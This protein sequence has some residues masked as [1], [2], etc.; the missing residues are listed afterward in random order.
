MKK[1]ALR[2]WYVLEDHPWMTMILG[3][4]AQTWFTL[5][6]R[7]LWFSDEVR[8]ADAY[9]N[10]AE[11]GHW[12]VLALNGQAYP[13]KPPVYFWF[14]WLLDTLTPADQPTVFFLGAALSGLFLLASAY[15][16]ARTLGFDRQVSLSAV[17]I[18]LSTFFLAGLFHYSRMDLMFAALIVL[19]HACLFRAFSEENQGRWP[20]WGF[21]LAGLATLVKGPLGFLFPLLTSTVYLIWKGEVKKFLTRPMGKGLL[22]MLLMLAAWVGGVILSQGP[23]FLLNTVLGHQILERATHTFH[24]M[25]PFYYYL[26]ALPL[27]WLPWTLFLFAAPVK[28]AFSLENW[29]ALWASR[30]EA[31]PRTFLWIMF[32]ATLIFLSSLSGKVLIYIL[33]MFPPMAILTG[34]AM[35]RQNEDDSVRFWTLA[36]GLLGLLG[37]G[38]LLGGDLLPFPVPMRGMGIAAITLLG[39][40]ALL[41]AVRKAG[42]RIA[43]LSTVLAV[44]VW[45][46]PVGLMVAPSL[47]NAMSPKRQGEMIGALVD[48][49][50]T[51]LAFKIYSGIFTYYADHEIEETGDWDELTSLVDGGERVVLSIREKHWK[52]WKDRP[53]GLRI[54][55]RQDIAG[56]IYLVVIKG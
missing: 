29:G 24:H 25:E 37:A 50:Y 28:R 20:L 18:L 43:L 8:Y 11:H 55:D 12:I 36:A 16:L 45:L 34:D 44:T 41:Y 53:E 49:G 27:A 40:A 56:M 7:A 30:R 42:N 10:L 48:E 26:I 15:A 47:D 31:G 14:L 35:T 1:T 46:Y 2:I 3:V 6:N 19:S 21:L 22:A 32:G 39:G 54:L 33:P 51:P 17:L 4:L 9:R 23:D 52:N 13:D 5:N 38:L